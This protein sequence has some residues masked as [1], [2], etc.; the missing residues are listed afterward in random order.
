MYDAFTFATRPMALGGN[1]AEIK[2]GFCCKSCNFYLYIKTLLLFLFNWPE[3][4]ASYQLYGTVYMHLDQE[5][6]LMNER[7]RWWNRPP[8][9]GRLTALKGQNYFHFHSLHGDHRRA[10]FRRYTYTYESERAS[11]RRRIAIGS[12]SDVLLYWWNRREGYL[13]WPW[14][15]EIIIVS[16]GRSSASC[17]DPAARAQEVG[18][19][20]TVRWRSNRTAESTG[21]IGP[22]QSRSSHRP[23]SKWKKLNWSQSSSAYLQISTPPTNFVGC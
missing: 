17:T 1:R 12:P 4:A 7:G 8:D 10:D 14:E 13:A 15:C 16:V 18:R 20:S 11:R 22:W 2:A 23:Q 9:G 19:S 3:R 6:E 5:M 21:R